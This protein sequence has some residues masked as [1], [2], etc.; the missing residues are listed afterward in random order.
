VALVSYAN[1]RAVL[2][3]AQAMV[4]GATAPAVPS[5]GDAR[6]G[7]AAGAVGG[8]AVVSRGAL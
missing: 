3:Q 6:A 7:G 8:G 5:A 2:E 4:A 1:A